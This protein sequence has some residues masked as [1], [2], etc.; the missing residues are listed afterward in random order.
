MLKFTRHPFVDVGAAAITAFA[1]KSRPEDLSWQDLDEV[2]DFIERHYTRDPLKSFLTAIFPNSGYV[3]PA[4]KPEKFAAF[5]NR[6]LYGYRNEESVSGLRCVYCGREASVRV[7]RQHVPMLT[8][9]GMLNFF[10]G[11]APGLPVCGFC[12][13]CIQ[14]FPLGATKSSGRTLIIHS[15]D[16]QVTLRAARN[17]LQD[18]L[19]YLNMHDITK[20]P[21]QKFPR[22][23]F[24]DQ[25]LRISEDY[26]QGQERSPSITLYHLTN[27][28]TTADVSIL[29]LPAQVV[30]F[31]SIASSARFGGVWREIVRR[32]WQS[33]DGARPGV[34]RNFL[35]EDLF[36]LPERAARF[37]QV[38]FLRQGFRAPVRFKDDPRSGYVLERELDLISW[39]LTAM[40]LREVMEMDAERIRAIRDLGDR[41][42]SYISRTNDRRFFRDFYRVD[43]YGQLRGL[44]IKASNAEVRSGRSPLIG[45]DE[46]IT[47]FEEGRDLPRIDWRLARDLVLIRMIERLHQEGKMLEEM[48]PEAEEIPGGEAAEG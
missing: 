3:Q 44:L 37:V 9:E 6:Y 13:L 35:Y 33:V 20:Y 17:F 12:L 48:T 42:S 8:G 2:A 29:H 14:A 4:M 28:G 18:N 24:V 32:A 11:A 15:D 38:Y 25:V 36:E 19:K 7:F 22:T 21:D 47:I 40:F 16:E 30:E 43:R 5:L 34:A 10:P 26:L 23:I 46:F 45:F 39:D 27:Y 1:G 41:L 31:L